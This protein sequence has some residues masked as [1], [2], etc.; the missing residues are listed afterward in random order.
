[1]QRHPFLVAFATCFAGCSIV[2]VIALLIYTPSS[3][4]LLAA[5]NMCLACGALYCIFNIY[6]AFKLTHTE[7]MNVEDYRFYRVFARDSTFAS[8]LFALAAIMLFAVC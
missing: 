4:S 3:Y 5:A 2:G 7:M 8:L 1:M 6:A